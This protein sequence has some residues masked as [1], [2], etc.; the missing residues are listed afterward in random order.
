MTFLGHDTRGRGPAAEHAALIVCGQ[1]D[2]LTPPRLARELAALLPESHL[3]TVPNAAH[4]VMAEAARRFNEI[5]LQFL[6]DDRSG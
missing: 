5:V 1:Q 6:E 2:C 4:L 3:V